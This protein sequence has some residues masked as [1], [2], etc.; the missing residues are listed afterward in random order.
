MVSD[1]LWGYISE[2][3]SKINDITPY[4]WKLLLAM[5]TLNITWLGIETVLG[6]YELAQLIEKMVV[7]G[8]SI[9]LI[10]NLAYI[11]QTFLSS[12]LKLT[13]MDT[14]ILEHPEIVFDFVH[15]DILDPVNAIAQSRTV[16]S[17]NPLETISAFIRNIPFYLT[18]G[19]VTIAIY[20]CF[21]IVV[22]QLVLNYISY[23]IILFFGLIL[24]PFSIFRPLEFIGKNV[25]KA[26]LTQALTLAVIVFVATLGLGIF[27]TMMTSAALQMFNPTGKNLLANMLVL[28]G[29]ILAYC[30]IC[31]QAPAIVM[32]IISG[33]P[34]LGAGGF[35]STMAG[36]GAAAAGAAHVVSGGVNAIRGAS[37]SGQAGQAAPSTASSGGTQGSQ[38]NQFMPRTSSSSSNTVNTVSQGQD[39]GASGASAPSPFLPASQSSQSSQSPQSSGAGARA[40]PERNTQAKAAA[41]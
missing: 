27:K 34:T 15:R 26:L 5:A 30:F 21:S 28:L 6:K 19:I 36:I 13:G 25:F 23:Y 12:L 10:K 39:A 29:S 8:I 2:I 9:F 7:L 37:S 16:N 1:L 14:E 35:F 31:L 38:G 33:A 11:S 41:T 22:V 40:E 20:I 24:L 3:L 32:G 17:I 4:T 18:F